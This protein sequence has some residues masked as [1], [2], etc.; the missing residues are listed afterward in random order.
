MEGALKLKEVSY[1][2][3]EAYPASELKHGPLALIAPETPTLVVLPHDDLLEKNLSS[4]QEV[5]ARKGPVI[6]LTHPG[7]LPIEVD[8][9]IAY[10]EDFET[11]ERFDAIGMGFVLEHVEDPGL[12]L[13]RYQD[14]LAPG[15]QIFIAVPNAESLHRRLGNFAGMLPD[16][17]TLSPADEAFGHRRYFTAETLRDLVEALE[18]LFG[19]DLVL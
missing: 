10:F 2:H 17:T 7:D 1:I 11:E 19:R 5:K 15:G 4:V 14:F 18:H 8:A 16:M 13:R 9:R 6:A 12:I 3:A